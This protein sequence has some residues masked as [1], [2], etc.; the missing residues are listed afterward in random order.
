MR[1]S[2]IALA[3][4]SAAAA[5]TS[6]SAAA[7]SPSSTVD[8]AQIVIDFKLNVAAKALPTDGSVGRGGFPADTQWGAVA[9]SKYIP[10]LSAAGAPAAAV[11]VAAAAAAAA[12][13]AL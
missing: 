2:V 3:L 5:Q 1:A 13:L 7:A 6:T 10:E 9:A 12:A 8:P 4:A 11:A